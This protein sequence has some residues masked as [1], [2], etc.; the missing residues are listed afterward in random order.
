[1]IN[2][3]HQQKRACILYDI[4]TSHEYNNNTDKYFDN[5]KGDR[6][7][8]FTSAHPDAYKERKI[9]ILLIKTE[10]LLKSFFNK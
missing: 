7:E 4:A 1:M 5:D 6:N 10:K 2:I 3:G 9:E 8:Y